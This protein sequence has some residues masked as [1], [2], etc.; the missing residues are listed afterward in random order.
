[1]T[2]P[3][4]DQLHH[5]CIGLGMRGIEMTAYKVLGEGARYLFAWHCLEDSQ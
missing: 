5:I 1:M 2:R 3:T 4:T